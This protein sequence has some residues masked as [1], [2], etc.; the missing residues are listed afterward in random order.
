MVD[1]STVGT[2]AESADGGTVSAG[3]CVRRAVDTECHG[4]SF[5]SGL[6]EPGLKVGRADSNTPLA[7]I[8]Y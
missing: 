4:N 3:T 7:A 2:G 1:T 5:L 8:G 6:A